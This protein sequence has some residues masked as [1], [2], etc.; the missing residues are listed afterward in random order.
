MC[1]IDQISLS[2]SKIE[3]RREMRERREQLGREAVAAASRGVLQQLADLPEMCDARCIMGYVPTRNEVDISP[4][5]RQWR[6]ENRRLYL[7]SIDW[8]QRRMW[9]AEIIHYPQDLQ[10][11]QWGILQPKM[12]GDELERQD[13]L[14]TIEVVLVPALA[15]DRQGHRLGFGGGFYDRFLGLLPA[16]TTVIGISYEF[17]VIA[18]VPVEEHD[19]AVDMVVTEQ[20]VYCV[21]NLKS[22]KAKEETDER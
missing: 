12:N 4:L 20:R 2:E 3:I 7:P 8:Q 14:P 19:L 16:A 1:A 13:I 18:G 21:S 22:R 9:P 5:L 11:G 15:F 17:Q 6:D 10:P